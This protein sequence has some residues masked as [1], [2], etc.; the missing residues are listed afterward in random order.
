VA[1]PRTD[2]LQRRATGSGVSQAQIEHLLAFGQ[3]LGGGG[4]QRLQLGVI[5]G[6]TQMLDTART[7]PR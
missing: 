7:A 5:M 6:R 1:G 3:A 2:D 4:L